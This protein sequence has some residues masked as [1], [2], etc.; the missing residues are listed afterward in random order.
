MRCHEAIPCN[1][2]FENNNFKT[3][4]KKDHEWGCG[5]FYLANMHTHTHFLF[6]FSQD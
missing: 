2:D 4:K 5:S 6:Y 3:K 1:W